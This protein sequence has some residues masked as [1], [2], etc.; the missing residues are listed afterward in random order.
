MTSR[1]RRLVVIAAAG[2][3]L[4]LWA[5]TA[6]GHGVTL[7]VHHEL[8]ADSPF[9]TQF[10]V[11]WTQKLEKESGGRLRFRL[12][13]ALQM[14]GTAPQ[15]YD[16][17]EGGRRGHRLGRRGL[18]ARALSGRR[19]VRAALRRE[20]RAGVQPGA[21]GVRAAQ[22]P[23]PQGARRRARAGGRPPRRA[24]AASAR[25]TRAGCRGSGGAQDR[26]SCTRRQLSGGA[27]RRPGRP[28]GERRRG[29]TGERRGGRGAAALG[30]GD[31]SAGS[32]MR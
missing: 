1:T 26:R 18:H 27:G 6:N 28:A 14:G 32:A 5:V 22:R 25:Q 15:L 16:Q 8:P 2:F 13:P 3:G 30:C 9:H 12:F 29:G 4:P 20:Q 24:P 19:G 21:L 23:G 11:P 31:R 7:K 10:L 17:V